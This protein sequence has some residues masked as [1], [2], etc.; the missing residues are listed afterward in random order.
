MSNSPAPDPKDPRFRRYRQGMIALYTVL[1]VAFCLHLVVSVFRSTAA[2]TFERPEGPV[3]TLSDAACREGL[4]ALWMELETRRG[5]M[6]NGKAVEADQAFLAFRSAWFP[7]FRTLEG[8]CVPGRPQQKAV[9]ADVEKLADLYATLSVRYAGEAGPT[10][11]RV[12]GALG[13]AP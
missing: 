13:A 11:D 1:T 12:R 8:G 9:F 7:R 4:R 2:M 5:E 3:P 10:V 6:A